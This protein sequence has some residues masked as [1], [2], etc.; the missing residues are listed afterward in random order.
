MIHN[1]RVAIVGNSEIIFQR[2]NNIDSF[3]VVVRLNNGFIINE[4][5]YKYLGS[6]TDILMVSGFRGP[7][8]LD[9]APNII[10]MTPKFRDK[11]T[12][13]ERN[14]LIFYPISWWEEL[15]SRVGCRPST[16]LMAVD[17]VS[18]LI[19]CGE[20]T[21]FGFDFW[22]SN[23]RLSGKNHIGPHSP[24][25]EESLIRGNGKIKDIII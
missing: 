20:I 5:H 16:G 22:Q 12:D 1:R 4:F 7:R 21:L 9:A 15:Y 11:L 10:W 8:V 19:G 17:L 3:D 13:L 18:R 23:N 24:A 2:E 25:V 6:R 14:T